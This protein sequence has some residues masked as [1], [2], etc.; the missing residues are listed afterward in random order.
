MQSKCTT[1]IVINKVGIE[2]TEEKITA[3]GGFSLLASFFERIKLKDVK[4]EVIPVHERSPNS[5]GKYSK[6]LSYLLMIYAGGNRFSHLLYLGCHEV[7][8]DLFAA[9]RL[10]LAATTLT[11][12]L[13]K[14][15]T[16]KE[17]EAMSEGL[18]GYCPN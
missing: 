12:L 15:K 17:V 7:L 1:K 13:G 6:I 9:G 10:P 2:F 11:R 14:I 4:E 18:W 5:R 16:M 3:Y 8:S